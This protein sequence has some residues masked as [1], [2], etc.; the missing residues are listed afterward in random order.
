MVVG[1]LRLDY[2]YPEQLFDIDDAD[3]FQ[4][5]IKYKLVKGLTFG[6]AQKGDA[7]PAEV[8]RELLTC[9]EELHT[10]PN[11]AGIISDC[12]FL[13]NYQDLAR[14]HNVSDS[15]KIPIAMSSLL[16]LPVITSI[17]ERDEQILVVT[18]N[19]S[20]L[21]P[22]FVDLMQ[23][24]CHFNQDF[25]QRTFVIIGGEEVE[26][27]GDEIQRGD[28]IDIAKAEPGFQS[29]ISDTINDTKHN[30]GAILFECTQLG[31]IQNGVREKF[32]LPVWDSLDL[33]DF[34]HA[35]ASW[36]VRRV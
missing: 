30:I 21:R 19:A 9:V 23:K 25:I 11:I 1:V 34:I 7:L 17:L 14:E 29:L 35:G 12:G 5:R 33:A 31:F 16:L 26:G 15:L 10:E 22:V 32:K 24:Y 18:A 36:H 13:I 6:L 2:D 3:S 20:A 4:Y 28:K 8:E 27:F